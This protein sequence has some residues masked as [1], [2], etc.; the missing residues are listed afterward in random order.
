MSERLHVVVVNDFASVTGGSDR[1]ALGEAAALARRGHR[2]TLVAGE[3]EAGPDLVAA[4]VRVLCTGQHSTIG[5]P[6]RLRAAVQG[7]WNVPAARLLAPV[8]READVV[9]LHGFTKV[10]S[11]SVVRT[12]VDSGRPL[13]ATLHDYFAACPNGGFFNYQTNEICTLTPLG[14]RCIAT[15]CDARSYVHKIWRV[16]RA[17]VQ[18]TAGAMPRGVDNL[19]V[20]SASA[21]EVLAPF[22]PP[23]ARLHVLPNSV[24]SHDELP[25]DPAANR[26]FVFLGRLSVDKGPAIF[27]RAARR[28]GVHAVFV[29]EGP[30]REAIR[31]A[32]PEAELTGWLTPAD[33]RERL[34]RARCLVSASLWYE[35]QGLSPLEAAAHAVPAIVSDAS[36]LRELVQDGVSGLWFRGGDVEDLARKLAALRDDDGAVVRMGRAAREQFREGGWDEATHL[37]RLEAV[38]RGLGAKNGQFR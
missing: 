35:T 14:P 20:P 11:P 4:G 36:V 34:R 33:V 5:D 17:A 19:I 3:G 23:G 22:L 25:I 10:L 13:V 2:V 26:D 27:A 1:V 21:G 31:R 12:A 16:G 32:N 38:Y 18:R 37:D 29:G 30:E 15:H 28:A 24:P 6:N 8:V 9:H 7:V